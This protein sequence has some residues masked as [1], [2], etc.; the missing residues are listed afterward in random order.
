M[1]GATSV[2]TTSHHSTQHTQRTQHLSLGN[3][4]L[5]DRR[6][7]IWEL[8]VQATSDFV[9]HSG[10]VRTF[11]QISGKP[12][13]WPW[14]DRHNCGNNLKAITLQSAICAVSSATSWYFNLREDPAFDWL[15]GLVVYYQLSRSYRSQSVTR[16][17]VR[18]VA[19]LQRDHLAYHREY[20]TT[21]SSLVLVSG[22]RQSVSSSAIAA[23]LETL[24]LRRVVKYWVQIYGWHFAE[25]QSLSLVLAAF[26]ST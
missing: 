5:T 1:T 3:L 21:D 7:V 13:I 17:E 2:T 6:P 18:G 4:V 10:I 26:E 8:T 19:A 11:D 22:I 9:T 15:I 23:S 24:L 14:G 25:E 16:C 20:R 12:V